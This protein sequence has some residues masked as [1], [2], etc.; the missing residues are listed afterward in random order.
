MIKKYYL[1]YRNLRKS[2]IRRTY[3]LLNDSIGQYNLNNYSTDITLRDYDGTWCIDFD[4]YKIDEP[5]AYLDGGTIC[6]VSKLP[7]SEKRFWK[8]V[9]E[10]VEAFLAAFH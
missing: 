10:K 7:L 4:V 9:Q 5:Q 3:N 8:I 1:N 6:N 2:L